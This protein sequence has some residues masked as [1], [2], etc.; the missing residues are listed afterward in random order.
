[1]F[2][3]N[4]YY[5]QRNV[6]FLEGKLLTNGVWD[7]GLGMCVGIVLHNYIRLTSYQS[8]ASVV[9]DIDTWAEQEVA[10]WCSSRGSRKTAICLTKRLHNGTNK[11]LEG[12]IY[13]FNITWREEYTLGRKGDMLTETYV[14]NGI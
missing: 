5:Q 9:D 4:D 7:E 8:P 2:S 11:L 12:Y 13:Q 6:F 1:M 10:R 14:T 3:F